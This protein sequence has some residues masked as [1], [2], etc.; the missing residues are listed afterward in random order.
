MGGT[1][2][3]IEDGT[4]GLLVP[5]GDSEALAN[6]MLEALECEESLSEL[7]FQGRQRVLENFSFPAQVSGYLELFDRLLPTE[8]PAQ[9]ATPEPSCD[10]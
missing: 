5:A 9:N 1:A 7:G 4:S 6:R 3:I 10:R 2:E 8:A